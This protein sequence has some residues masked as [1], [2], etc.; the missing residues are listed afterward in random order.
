LP[1]I[2][3]ALSR[4]AGRYFAVWVIV[5]TVIG[6]IRPGLVAWVGP[7]IPL[8]LGVIMF[9]MG[10]TLSGT[11]FENALKRPREVAIG[12]L[13]Q[14]T[15]MPLVAYGLALV[16]RL[17]PEL[18]VGVILVGTCPGGTASNVVTY[19]ARGDLALSVSMT[20][21]ATL[22]APILTPVLTLWLAGE[23]IPVP[24]TALFLSILKIV[25][26]PVAAGIVAHRFLSTT[27]ERLTPILPLVS[28]SAIVAIVAFVVSANMERILA[29]AATLFVAVAL[30]N[31]IGLGLGYALSR[32]LGLTEAKRRAVTIEVGMQ[33]SGLAV[34]L[35]AVHFNPAA[36]IPGAL[37]SVWHNLTG[38]ALATWWAR[39]PPD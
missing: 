38:P 1:K 25:L 24:A 33:N 30:H 37:F 9:G 17:P 21:V 5:G 3:S 2:L 36:A 19:L 23:W 16:L 35:A 29:T 11:D 34:S 14:F 8:L 32:A 20:S 18:A 6:S 28:V 10:M 15:I 12:V 27:V 13:A 39:R 31:V 4:F 26:L 7:Q 22:L